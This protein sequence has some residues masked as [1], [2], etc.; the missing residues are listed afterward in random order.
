MTFSIFSSLGRTTE[1]PRQNARKTPH[2]VPQ[3][4]NQTPGNQNRHEILIMFSKKKNS[5]SL[6]ITLY[7]IKIDRT[8]IKLFIITF[9]D[10]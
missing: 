10:V 6:Q 2:T 5:S 1:V 9:S 3:V 7:V 4:R 8:F